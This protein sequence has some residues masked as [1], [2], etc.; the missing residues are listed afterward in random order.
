MNICSHW[1][2]DGTFCCS[3][4][5]KVPNKVEQ[6]MPEKCSL[7]VGEKF[8]IHSGVI[9]AE[10]IKGF[11]SPHPI[12]TKPVPPLTIFLNGESI[13]LNHEDIKELFHREKER[14]ITKLIDFMRENDFKEKDISGVISNLRSE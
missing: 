9:K 13:T 11:L 10:D 4:G 8:E 14:K 2:I 5:D 12:R 1:T 3:C 7:G 6:Y